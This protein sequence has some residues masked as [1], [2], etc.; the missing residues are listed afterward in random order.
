MSDY[1]QNLEKDKEEVATYFF[2]YVV[3]ILYFLGSSIGCCVATLLYIWIL[4]TS[5]GGDFV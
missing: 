3:C 1:Y 2:I 5:S 4:L